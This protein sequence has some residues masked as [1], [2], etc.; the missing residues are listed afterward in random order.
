MEGMTGMADQSIF[1]PTRAPQLNEVLDL[2]KGI[3]EGTADEKDFK[4]S[5]KDLN[6]FRRLLRRVLRSE[7]RF[8]KSPVLEREVPRM[9]I[10]L[11][12]LK[13]GIEEVYAF[14]SDRDRNH[15]SKGLAICRA[16]IDSFF[17]SIDAL[18][19]EEGEKIT[20][21]ES[22]YQN[23][24]MRVGYAVMKGIL[25]PSMLKERLEGIMGMMKAFYQNFDS[26]E[27]SA[28]ERE[29]FL[30]KRQAI[31]SKLH[32]YIKS[33]QEIERYF[34]DH[35]LIHLEKGLGASKEAAD[36]LMALQHELVKVSE[37]PRTKLCFRCG[38]ENQVIA[39]YCAHCNATFPSYE[40]GEKTSMEFRMDDRGNVEAVSHARTELSMRLLDGVSKMRAGSL[41]REH[42][43]RLLDEL[44][45]KA[46][47]ARQEKGRLQL[48][49]ELYNN[50]TPSD[51]ELFE[52][53]EALMTG[54]IEEI[55]E[56]LDRMKLYIAGQDE[57]S[58]TVGLEKVLCGAD[59]L[60]H[61]QKLT[62]QMKASR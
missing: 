29:I 35:D 25:K 52:T 4:R 28:P 15:I 42:F 41:S 23:E 45:Q 53:M 48:P 14:F 17:S 51:I 18:N 59:K 22:P 37:G 8:Y 43:K 5:V 27:P 7:A 40:M 54:G 36:T 60:S 21:S 34:D 1:E 56:G 47:Q 20:Y 2:A 55:A 13:K 24:L 32:A 10:E 30:E 3:I 11:G 38:K 46:L 57:T 33:L 62:E 44:E 19:K 39:K 31:K 16:S 58:L 50:G 9:E 26:L 12:H 49:K 61:V 6:T